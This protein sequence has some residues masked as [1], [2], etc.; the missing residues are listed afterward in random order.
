MLEYSVGVMMVI[1]QE[2]NKLKAELDNYRPLSPELMAVIYDKIKIEWT[3]HSNAIEGNTLTLQETSFFLQHGLTS[4]GKTLLEYLEAQNHAEAIDWLQN[5]TKQQRPIT[6]GLIKELHTLLLRGIEHVLVGP[7]GNKIK[8]RITPGAYKLQPNHVLTVDGKVHRYCDPIGVPGEMAKLI[9]WLNT[10]KSHPVEA[11]AR[12]HYR[13]VAIHPFDDGNGRVA[14]LLMNLLLMRAGFLPVII[15]NEKREDYYRA[16]MEADGG[17]L[18][19]FISLIAH[20][21]K[22]SLMMVLE[23]IRENNN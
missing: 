2:L 1:Y 10:Q 20:E 9:T 6:E 22:D 17:D 11:A 16:L 21:A 3:Y 5:I 19:P 4:K 15:K 8:K 18:E 23:I 7:N 12:A 13:L 14:R